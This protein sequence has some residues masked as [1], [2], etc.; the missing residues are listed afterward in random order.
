MISHGPCI[1]TFLA[2]AMAISQAF[3]A[4]NVV[5]SRG[6]AGSTAVPATPFAL[7]SF[8]PR[9]MD[10]EWLDCAGLYP[11]GSQAD[12]LAQEKE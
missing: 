5:K 1:G 9:R 12:D 6:D 3:C 8:E 11:G 10:D 2:G 4:R 7:D